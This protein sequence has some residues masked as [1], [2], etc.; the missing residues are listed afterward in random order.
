MQNFIF[1]LIFLLVAACGKSKRPRISDNELFAQK[2]T[3]DTVRQAPNDS[4]A[5]TY[6]LSP[7]QQ[8]KIKTMQ[9]DLG[10]SEV[11]IMILE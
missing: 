1:L 9:S 10:E 8:N 7:E 4:I 3:T 2:E 5:E 6:Y 11:L